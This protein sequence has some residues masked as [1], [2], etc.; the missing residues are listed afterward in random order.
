MLYASL[1]AAS[2]E[3]QPLS[4]SSEATEETDL[5]ADYET[6]DQGSPLVLGRGSFGTVYSAIDRVTK[7]KMAV[8]EIVSSEE[9]D[10]G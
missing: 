5:E 10:S 7:K 1:T 6:D 2:N 4:L 9:A 3:S 8:K